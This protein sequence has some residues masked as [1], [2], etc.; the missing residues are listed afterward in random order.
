MVPGAAGAVAVKLNV[1]EAPGAMVSPQVKPARWVP[2]VRLFGGFC[3]PSWWGET[4]QV[5][6]TV[7]EFC[8]VTDTG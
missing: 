6:P 7:P 2:H 4:S 1:F 8:M 5:H 3:E